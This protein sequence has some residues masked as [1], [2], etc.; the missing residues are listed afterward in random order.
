MAAKTVF[1]SSDLVR[2]IYS[3]GDPDHRKVMSA[4]ACGIERAPYDFKYEYAAHKLQMRPEDRDAYSM[5]L[6]LEGVPRDRLF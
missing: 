5:F 3:F 6:Y 1:N 2:Y 4:I